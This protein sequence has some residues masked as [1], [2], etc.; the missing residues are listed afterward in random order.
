ME[1]IERAEKKEVDAI[2]TNMLNVPG[3]ASAMASVSRPT[4][5]VSL[6]GKPGR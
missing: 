6:R 5:S 3:V 1:A 2:D 4:S